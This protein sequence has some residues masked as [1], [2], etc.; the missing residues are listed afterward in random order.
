MNDSYRPFFSA[1]VTEIA[2]VRAGLR[3][4]QQETPRPFRP[5]PAGCRNARLLLVV[6]RK[7]RRPAATGEFVAAIMFATFRRRRGRSPPSPPR[8]TRSR[9][10]RR[11][12]PGERR[13]PSGPSS[14]HLPQ[15]VSCGTQLLPVPLRPHDGAISERANS[16]RHVPNAGLLFVE[17]PTAFQLPRS[18]N[19]RRRFPCQDTKCNS[20]SLFYFSYHGARLGYGAGQ[21]AMRVMEI[22]D[23][24]GPG[25]PGGRAARPDPRAPAQ[26][27]LLVRMEAASIN[28][29]DFVMVAG[30]LRPARRPPAHDPGF[31]RRR[32]SGCNR[33]GRH[34]GF[35]IGDLGLSQFRAETGPTDS[36]TRTRPG[37]AC[38]AGYRDGVLQE[39]DAVPAARR[40]SGRHHTSTRFEAASLA[41]RRADRL[42]RAGIEAGVKPGDTV[43]TQGTR[44]RL[45]LR[46]PVREALRRRQ[47]SSL[48]RATT[49]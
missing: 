12:I 17:A 31:R 28:Y 23:A 38:W 1:R 24:M 22:R 42:E 29:R 49:S 46:P 39:A 3:L 13:R 8:R 27:R 37:P 14:P 5:T 36:F 10:R 33:K 15:N 47:S 26:A 35:A 32:P 2:G 19:V 4:A 11:P 6:I 9:R 48:R 34:P 30:R 45:P 43:L 7:R 18:S 41:L 40:R 44:R 16:P 20:E 25:P 21:D